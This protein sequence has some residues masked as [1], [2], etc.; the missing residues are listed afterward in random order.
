MLKVC[1]YCKKIHDSKFICQEK[2]QAIKNRQGK[3]NHKFNSFRWSNQWR[4]KANEIKERDTFLCQACVR[5]LEGTER[6]YNSDELSVHHIVSLE[7]DYSMRLENENLITLCRLHH[8][9]AEKGDIEKNVL[10][11]AAAEQEQRR[12]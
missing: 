1:C 9:L 2:K 8:E 6:K 7:N 3:F 10:L 4:K 5:E 11:E 12:E